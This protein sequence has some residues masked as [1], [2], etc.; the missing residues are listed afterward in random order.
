[1]SASKERNTMEE[2]K[3]VVTALEREEI[4][5]EQKITSEL[6]PFLNGIRSLGTDSRN[7][8]IFKEA[9]IDFENTLERKKN[10]LGPFYK[11]YV[12]R[13]HTLSKDIIHDI[14]FYL[15]LV[16]SFGNCIADIIVLLLVA[17]GRDLHI[18]CRYTRTPRIKHVTSIKE[19]ETERVPLTTKLNFLD[20]NSVKELASIIDSELR[21]AIAHLKFDVRD[22]KIFIK[23]KSVED[24]VTHSSLKLAAAIKTTRTLIRQLA[25]DKGLLRKGLDIHE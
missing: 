3:A 22:D 21:N 23:G 20:D 12:E 7:F 16:E 2:L 11:S 19:L 6:T 8:E 13:A 17:N 4:Q 1:M 5:T 24:I 14:F 25:K 10:I 18:E 15:G 9:F